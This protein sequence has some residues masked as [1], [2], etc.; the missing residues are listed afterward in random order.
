MSSFLK[1]RHLKVALASSL[2][3]RKPLTIN[4]NPKPKENPC[5][6]R[7]TLYSKFNTF[8]RIASAIKPAP[9]LIYQLVFFIVIFVFIVTYCVMAT[10]LTT[11]V[12]Y[13]KFNDM[14]E[15]TQ[16]AS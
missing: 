10:N 5:I 3:I 8:R 14:F 2:F 9:M 7:L 15:K 16:L 11:F 1:Y 13:Y 4:T 6:N 12:R